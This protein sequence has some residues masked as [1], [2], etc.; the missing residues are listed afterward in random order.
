[1]RNFSIWEGVVRKNSKLIIEVIEIIVIEL[2]V[3]MLE[4]VI[5]SMI[6][7]VVNRRGM[8]IAKEL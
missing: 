3:V 7:V 2:E 8:L 6:I 1:M 5:L 4:K